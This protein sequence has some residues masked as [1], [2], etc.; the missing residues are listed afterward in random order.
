MEGGAGGGGKER[1]GREG[2]DAL[3]FNC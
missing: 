3:V 2:E 1:K